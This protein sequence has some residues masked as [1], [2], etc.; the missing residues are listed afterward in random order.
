MKAKRPE[1]LTMMVREV[2]ALAKRLRTDIRRAARETG[3]TKNLERAAVALRKRV[4]VLMAQLERYVHELRMELAAA[5]RPAIKRRRP[6][7]A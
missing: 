3:L 4:A 1:R 6:R 5:P 2:E 7:A